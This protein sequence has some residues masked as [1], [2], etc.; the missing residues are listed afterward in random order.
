MSSLRTQ[1]PIRRG[2]HFAC[3]GGYLFQ[4]QRPVVMGPCV[5]RDD[6]ELWRSP[7]RRR[8]DLPHGTFSPPKSAN[9]P[10]IE[11]IL[12][13]APNVSSRRLRRNNS[14]PH[15]TILPFACRRPE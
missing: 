5:R 2:G 7:S 14:P 9:F 8:I 12:V 3:A 13:F 11:I 6:D 15:E 1:R 4:Q 10:H